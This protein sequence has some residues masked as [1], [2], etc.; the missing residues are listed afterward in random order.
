LPENHLKK[1]KK[2]PKYYVR[3]KPQL[4]GFNAVHKENCP[5]LQDSNKKLYLGEYSSSN[6]AIMEA[7]GYFPKSKGCL[8]CTSERVTETNNFLLE[9]NMV[10][11]S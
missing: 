9:W 6:E 5:F 4:N 1:N 11:L 10:S 2:M 3:I 7:K 8:F